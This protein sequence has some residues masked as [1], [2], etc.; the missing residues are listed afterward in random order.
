MSQLFKTA[1]YQ[2]L[3]AE[4]RPALKQA[5]AR[6][7][8]A[9]GTPIPCL[10]KGWF[11]LQVQGVKLRHEMWVA[12]INLEAILGFDFL[13]RH[14]CSLNVRD[15]ELQINDYPE[16][17]YS[18]EEEEP[19]L[20]RVVAAQTVDIPPESEAS[21]QDLSCSNRNWKPRGF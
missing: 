8:T 17:P 9:D 13:E 1:V 10:G 2:R 4:S 15:G 21:Y 7:V 18:D 16:S 6:M 3:S 11:E 20:I 5:T 14:D 19:Q 12:D